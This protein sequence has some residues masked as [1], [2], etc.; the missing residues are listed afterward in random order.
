MGRQTDENGGK[1]GEGK[2]IGGNSCGI[3]EKCLSLTG[4]I[5]L[6]TLRL[7]QREEN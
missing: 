4:F 2:N 1:K 3:R 7:W 5:T 6:K